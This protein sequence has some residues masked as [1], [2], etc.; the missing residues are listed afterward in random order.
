MKPAVNQVELHPY[1]T[2]VKLVRYW[3]LQNIV[4]TAYS[5]LGAGSYVECDMSKPEDSCL[6]EEVIQTIANQREKS[7]AQIILRWAI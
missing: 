1:L 4:V 7:A 5:P 6:T 3:H 2:Q